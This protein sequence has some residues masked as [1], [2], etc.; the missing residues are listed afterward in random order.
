MFLS[1]IP[2]PNIFFHS[3]YRIWSQA[4]LSRILP[5]KRD[6]KYPGKN[7]RYLFSCF[8]WFQE[9]VFKVKNITHPVSGKNSSRIQGV[10]KHRIPDPDPQ[11]WREQYGTQCIAYRK[12][13]LGP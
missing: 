3:G 10:K 12:N 4:F 2:D 7:Y 9:E 11:H 8:L 13:L 1:R 5:K 6:E